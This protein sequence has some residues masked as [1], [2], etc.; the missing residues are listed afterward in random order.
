MTKEELSADGCNV[1]LVH[2]DLMI[3]SDEVLRRG[4]RGD[5]TEEPIIDKGRFAI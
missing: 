2:V 1:S 3:G 5:G 4:I